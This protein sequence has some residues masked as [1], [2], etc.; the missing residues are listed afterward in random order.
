LGVVGVLNTTCGRRDET[1]GEERGK[2]VVR[3]GI[4]TMR[5]P[6]EFRAVQILFFSFYWL[7]LTP[8]RTISLLYLSSL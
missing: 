4:K 6:F 1:L 7:R 2:A 3:V 5:K 8:I